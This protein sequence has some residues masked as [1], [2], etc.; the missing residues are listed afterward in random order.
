MHHGMDIHHDSHAWTKT[1]TLHIKNDMNLTF[2]TSTCVGHLHCENQVC[3]YI[4]CIHHTSLMNV[5]EWNGFTL[6]TFV[7]GQ[8]IPDGSTLVCKICKV[9]QIYI[10][11]CGARIYYVFGIDNMTRVCLHI[12]LHKH[13]V[14]AG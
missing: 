2:C 6:T 13:L 14:R 3:K 10:A 4:A 7:V 1:I 11:P 5:I 12:R 8:P 9:P